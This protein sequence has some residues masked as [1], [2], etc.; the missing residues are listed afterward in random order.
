M[1][2]FSL[3]LLVLATFVVSLLYVTHCSIILLLSVKLAYARWVKSNP[4]GSL[5]IYR[6]FVASSNIAERYGDPVQHFSCIGGICSVC[7]RYVCAVI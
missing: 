1:V 7:R 2:L 4:A 6:L 3:V 5:N